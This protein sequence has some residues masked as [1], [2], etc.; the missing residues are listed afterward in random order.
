[1]TLGDEG[2]LCSGGDGSYA[3][4]CGE[5]VDFQKNL[6]I[7]TLDYGTFHLY[8]DSWG[9]N[10]TWGNTWILEHDA[11]GKA[12]NKP[13]VLEEYGAV[14]DMVASEQQW[15]ATVLNQTEIAAD[16]FWQFSTTLPSGTNDGDN[17][18]LQYGSANYT[19]LATTHAKAMLAK[20]V[21]GVYD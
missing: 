12:A 2:W 4:G 5:G 19:I 16:Q 17:F 14:V 10:E 1:M 15:Q 11:I 6:G 20:N 3:Y 13:V 8:P 18:S 7:S 21:N 9:Y